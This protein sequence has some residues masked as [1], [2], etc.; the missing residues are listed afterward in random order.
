MHLHSFLL[1]KK[2]NDEQLYEQKKNV[3]RL[4]KCNMEQLPHLNKVS[5]SLREKEVV[6]YGLIIRKQQKL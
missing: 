5:K 4:K 6:S 2:C 3:L 1:L